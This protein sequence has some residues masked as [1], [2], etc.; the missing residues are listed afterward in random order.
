MS[1][2][3]KCDNNLLLKCLRELS[4]RK[5]Y[6]NLFKVDGVLISR[7]SSC[8][9]LHG[10]GQFKLPWSWYNARYLRE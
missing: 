1:V 3:C 7:A 10:K 4:D 2:F 8:L 5:K 6:G 9:T